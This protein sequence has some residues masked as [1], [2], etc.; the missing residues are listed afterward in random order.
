M[1]G[2]RVL[3]FA[4][5]DRTSG[6]VHIGGASVCLSTEGNG[7]YK[8]R[9]LAEF[10]LWDSSCPVLRLLASRCYRLYLRRKCGVKSN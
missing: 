7:Q 5:N 2:L 4:P 3:P 6:V 1:E 8:S 9:T 10:R